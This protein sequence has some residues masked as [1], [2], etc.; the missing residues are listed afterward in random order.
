MLACARIGATHS[1]V[2]GGFSA[3]ALRDRMNDAQANGR[4]SPPT[5]AIAAARSCRSR[6]TSTTPWRE[7]PSVKDVVVVRRT[8][9]Q[10]AMKAGR[11]HWW[12]ELMDAASPDCPAE[13]LDAEH[14]L[15]ILYTS[16]TTGKPK[17]V[18]HTTGGYLLHATCSTR[19][20]L[21]SEGRGHLLVH[22][23]HRLGDRPQLRRLRPA[24]ERRDVGD[25]RGRAEPARARTASGRSSTTLRRHDLLH[26]ADRDPRVHQVGRG[27]AA[28]ARPRRR[29]AC[30]ARSA[31]RS[32]PKRGCG[33]TA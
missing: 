16:G 27:V 30:S 6:R 1:V 12:H 2:F 7:S 29:C 28:Q 26:R 14:P 24:R 33:T 4:S 5:A 15:F 32:I 13:P 31:S 21:R 17:G 3:E 20:G 10:V 25:V 8:G 9:E 22:R 18:V 11:D 23:R 19:V